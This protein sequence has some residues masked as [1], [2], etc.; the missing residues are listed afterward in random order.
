MR[1]HEPPPRHS[2]IQQNY[3]KWTNPLLWRT[4]PPFHYLQLLSPPAISRHSHVT[5]CIHR[6]T[7]RNPPEIRIPSSRLRSHARTRSSTRK[8][9]AGRNPLHRST[10]RKTAHH[11]KSKVNDVIKGQMWQRRFYDFNVFTQEKQ[12]E[13]LLYMHENPVRRG[14]VLSA[15]D[16]KWGSARF[17]SSGE[18]SVVKILDE[19]IPT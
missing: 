6:N 4:R 9:A 1:K 13:K 3:A 18:Q 16:W 2:K 8:R 11:S 7:G 5:R 19:M 12:T 17:Y 15:E 14:L 10:S